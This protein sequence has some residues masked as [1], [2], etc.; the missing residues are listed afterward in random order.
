MISVSLNNNPQSSSIFFPHWSSL[1][2]ITPGQPIKSTMNKMLCI[3]ALEILSIH[4][5]QMSFMIFLVIGSDSNFLCL[6]KILCYIIFQVTV[7]VTEFVKENLGPSF[8]ESPPT[9]LP[10]LFA[11]MLN[12]TPLVFV[13]STGSDPMGAFQRFARERGYQDR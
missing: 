12:V 5:F 1:G 3:G 8:I 7:A 10:T 11:D 6:A 4:Y 13:L 9:D 2:L